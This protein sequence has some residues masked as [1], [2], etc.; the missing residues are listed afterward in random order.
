MGLVQSPMRLFQSILCPVDFSTT[1]RV[2]LQHAV[3]IAG[4]TGGHLTAMYADDP[5]LAAAAAAGYNHQLLT[6]QTTTALRQLLTRVGV[7]IGRNPK[8]AGVVSAVGRPPREIL[9]VARRLGTDLIV[10]G[11]QGR[12]GAGKWFFGS[13]TDQVLRRTPVPV[14]AVPHG[15]G[16]GRLKSW[17][18]NDI[19]CAIELSP[20]DREDVRAA[21]EI[22]RAF[23]RDLTLVHVVRPTAGPP[24]LVGK[25]RIHDRARLKAAHVT[26]G[27]LARH[28][29]TI[30]ERP[31]EARALLGTP[32]EEIA[33]VATDIGA[34]LIVLTLR[35]GHGLFGARQGSVTYQVLSGAATPVLALRQGSHPVRKP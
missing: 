27:D 2:A 35:R 3:A 31:V 17:P 28:A 18:G 34:G 26:L 22:A 1:S 11:T 15:A 5:M 30:L 24:W 21:A 12:S 20:R 32:A 13:V 29:G 7:P 23:H 10:M 6:K 33:A 8:A 25:L 16:V 14:L 19:L 9:N 4:Q